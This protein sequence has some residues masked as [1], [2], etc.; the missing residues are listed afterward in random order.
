MISWSSITHTLAPTPV[1]TADPDG[2]GGTV[3]VIAS[4]GFPERLCRK[5]DPTDCFPSARAPKTADG[6]NDRTC[7]PIRRRSASR[8][9]P[10][11][12]A[13]SAR[14]TTAVMVDYTC[15]DNRGG[16]VCPQ[17]NVVWKN[18]R[19]PAPGERNISEAPGFDNLLLRVRT[20]ARRQIRV[21]RGILDPGVLARGGPGRAS[22]CPE[23]HD[24]SWQGG[25]LQLSAAADGTAKP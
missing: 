17:H 20:D 11:S 1:T 14:D 12:T 9:K 13:T 25:F 16:I 6:P 4:K 3:Y 5:A 23:G 19:E 22:T 21:S 10:P 18:G 24:N 2:S 8:A 7:G 15:A